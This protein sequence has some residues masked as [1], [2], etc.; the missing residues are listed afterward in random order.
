MV[1]I[2]VVVSISKDDASPS[3]RRGTREGNEV[4]RPFVLSARC[5]RR[6]DREDDDQE[7]DDDG[8]GKGRRRGPEWCRG[9][10][11]SF[12]RVLPCVEGSVCVA[13]AEDDAVGHLCALY[14]SIAREAF[15]P[16]GS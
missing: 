9:K 13:D 2:P 5:A 10:L 7:D 1:Q 4:S 11:R 8:E 12:A 15:W 6:H 16:R 14:H 3:S